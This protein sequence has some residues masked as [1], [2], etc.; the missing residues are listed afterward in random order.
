MRV[1]FSVFG[2]SMFLLPVLAL[3]LSIGAKAPPIELKDFEGNRVRLEDLKGSIVLVNFWATWCEPCKEELPKLEA[4]Y[5]KYRAQGF[6]VL[7]VNL[8]IPR[9]QRRAK[10]LVER[11]KLSFPIGLD[12]KQSVPAK[13]QPS[14]MPSSFLIDAQ[15]NIRFKHEGYQA[16]DEAKL[17]AAIAR[18]IRLEPPS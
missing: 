3:A 12:P 2:G 1:F 11:M 8:D 6:V 13:Y 4:L 16:G 9:D 14:K 10:A 7:G 15:G 17:E 18:L 5:Q